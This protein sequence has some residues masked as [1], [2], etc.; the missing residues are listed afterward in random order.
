MVSIKN[1]VKIQMKL[2]YFSGLHLE[3]M[4]ECGVDKIL[5]TIKSNSAY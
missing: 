3:F 2:R 4:D 5:K 1:T